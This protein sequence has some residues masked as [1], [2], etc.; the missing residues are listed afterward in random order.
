MKLDLNLGLLG[1]DNT[2]C[3]YFTLPTK[4]GMTSPQNYLPQKSSDKFD[5]HFL[6]SRQRRTLTQSSSKLK[7][8][9]SNHQLR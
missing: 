2:P 7:Q 3:F 4:L 1:A 6:L 8:P 9:F 5:R